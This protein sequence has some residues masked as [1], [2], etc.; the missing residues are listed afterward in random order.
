[1]TADPSAVFSHPVALR[2]STGAGPA[3]VRTA[4]APT[5]AAVAA[6]LGIAGIDALEVEV[7]LESVDGVYRCRGEVRAA[8][9]QECVV[10]REPVAQ[11]IT[12]AFERFLVVGRAPAAT[13]VDVDPDE[14]DVDY[15]DEPV[16]DIGAVA[17]EEL[18]LALDPYP[19][20]AGA[21][22]LIAA[23]NDAVDDGE[24]RRPFAVLARQ[25]GAS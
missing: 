1:M 12:A 23:C 5:R 25:G 4:D 14:R 7:V 9:T 24:A 11:T 16:V 6:G 17:V 20:A 10:T 21:D 15:L 3:I 22:A 18:A 13:T 8:V 19:R 2:P